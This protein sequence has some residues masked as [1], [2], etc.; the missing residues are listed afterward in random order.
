MLEDETQCVT[1]GDCP[2][3][4]V[5]AVDK[6]CRDGCSTDNDCIE[7]QVCSYRTCADKSELGAD[8]ELPVVD[9][10]SLIGA[11]C[12]RNSDCTSL[13]SLRGRALRLRSAPPT[14]TA[15]SVSTAPTG[16]VRSRRPLGDCTRRTCA[17][18]GLNCGLAPDGCGGAIDC[19]TVADNDGCKV[20]ETCGGGG[21][22]NVCGSGTCDAATSCAQQGGECGVASDGCGGVVSCGICIGEAK[23]KPNNRCECVAKSCAVLA[24]EAGIATELLCGE[25]P[26]GCGGTQTC[27]ACATGSCGTGNR[28]D[29]APCQNPAPP[30]ACKPGQCG[31]VSNGCTGTYP[32]ATCTGAQ[33]CGGGGVPNTCGCIPTR[34]CAAVG[35]GCGSIDD[36]VRR[37]ARL[38]RVSSGLHLRRGQSVQPRASD[39]QELP[40]G[41]LGAALVELRSSSRR[42][43]AAASPTWRAVR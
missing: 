10:T 26:D 14:S 43:T 41:Q 34:T 29:G 17:E 24:A 28:C 5:C 15:R 8:D 23:C 30:P 42:R 25:L 22:A 31:D 18:L 35:S 36:G 20:G 6:E 27:G 13:P 1:S 4:E 32:C 12:V 40:P 39:V 2:G 7:G 9:A 21:K 3:G 33:S 38:R 19:R 37:P 11:T 16:S